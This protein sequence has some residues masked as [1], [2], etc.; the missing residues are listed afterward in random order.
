MICR[1]WC[2]TISASDIKDAYWGSIENT[3]LEQCSKIFT[4]KTPNEFLETIQSVGF[5][6]ESP[7]QSGTGYLENFLLPHYT[8]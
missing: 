7:N 6:S 2:F 8:A 4:P 1:A 5:N 3:T